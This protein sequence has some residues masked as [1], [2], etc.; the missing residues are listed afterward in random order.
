MDH[1]FEAHHINVLDAIHKA[2]QN[3]VVGGIL[4]TLRNANIPWD[5]IIPV[6]MAQIPNIIAKNWPPVIAALIALA[7]TLFPMNPTPTGS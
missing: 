4:T 7:P 5:K 1:Q 6:V 3:P 2:T